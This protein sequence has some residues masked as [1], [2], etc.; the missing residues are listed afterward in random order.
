MTTGPVSHEPGSAASDAALRWGRTQEILHDVL[1]RAP[2]ERAA[3][4][5][6]ACADLT[7][8]RELEQLIAAHEHPGALDE[9]SRAVIAPLQRG[10]A[11]TDAGAPLELGRYTIIERL[12]GGGMGV[13]HRAHDPR[14]GRDVALKF[15]S[16]HL[17]ADAT[18]KKR[19]MVEARATAALE[20]PNICTIHEIGETADG[21]LYIVM[22]YYDGETLDRLIAR[23]PMAVELALR[24]AADIA[25]GLAKAHERGI[26]HRDI[27]PANVMI[28]SDGLVKILDFGIAK[29]SDSSA[30]HTTGAL[31]TTA[32]MS[33]EQASAASLDHRTDLW[34]L[35]IVLY[36]MLTGV[37]PFRGNEPAILHG[38]LH[39]DPEPVTRRRPDAPPAIESA[40][41][42]AL[43]KRA[44][45]RYASAHELI[46][47]LERIAAA[48]SSTAPQRIPA[49]SRIAAEALD[50]TPLTR[51]GER[52]QVTVVECITHDYA[53]L[54]ERLV[55]EELERLA[56]ALRE[57]A[58]EVASRYGGI[59]NHVTG[60]RLVMLFGVPVAHEDDLLR[61]ARATLE[62][63]ARARELDERHAAPA[64]GTV[65]LRS[66]VHSGVAIAQRLRSGDQR[67]HIAG[68]PAELAHRLAVHAEPDAILA[69]PEC[70][71]L[72][73]AA[74]HGEPAPP[75][76]LGDDAPP[77]TPYRLLREA[78]TDRRVEFAQRAA[79]TPYS[80]RA[81]EIALC[82]EQLAS[83]LAGAGRMVIVIGDAGT[84]KSRLL[85]EL[86]RYAQEAGVGV[87]QGRCDAF[88]RTT[89]YLPFGQALR[90]ALDVGARDDLRDRH[91]DIV[92]R[93]RGI[94]ESLEDFLPLYLSLLAIPSAT[95]P[96]PRHLQGEH[97]QAA[98]V[99]ALAALFTIRATRTPSLLA[100]EDWHWA[101]EASRELL[102]QL[103]HLVPAYPLLL[104]VTARADET[105]SWGSDDHQHLVR[106]GPLDPGA[107]RDIVRAVLGA[108]HVPEMLAR[109]LHERTGGNP[110]FLEE[111]CRALREEEIVV[112]RG[113]EAMV[114]DAPRVAHLPETVQAVI[115]TRIDR[116][117]PHARDVLRVASVFGRDFSRGLLERVADAPLDVARARASQG[118]RT[119]RPDERGA[120]VHLPLQAR[121]HAGGG[122]RQPARASAQVAARCHGARDRE[123][124]RG[125]PR[126]ALRLARSPLQPR[127]GVAARD[128][129]R[130]GGRRPRHRALP[131]RGCVEHPRPRPGLAA[132]PAGD[133]RA[134]GAARR[135]P[136]AAG[137][138]VRDARPARATASP[139]R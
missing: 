120:R 79:L 104:V 38:L 34:S 91:D 90:G 136:A 100:L 127:R 61:A 5:E 4:L 62:L 2:A 73:G 24:I 17:S 18:A 35:G 37:R 71:R 30:I 85:F 63:H 41:A 58:V 32:Y 6:A 69:S 52:R 44:A 130:H 48:A 138:A 29:L 117:E 115:R 83:A 42:R 68:S 57:A 132:T 66:G 23:G 125:S 92:A 12:G 70:R 13:V 15:L 93:I 31:G 40:L 137:A 131:V 59:V 88:G 122:V 96:V 112:V 47:D 45:D 33:P 133:E 67:F 124:P 98:L 55:P 134:A 103:T 94:G 76:V 1:A 114:R 105:A 60:D 28:T 9:L 8:R 84:G 14:L 108:Q 119:H 139:H 72:V 111:M 22:A 20:H 123:P 19:F 113:G 118:L 39:V 51:S 7:M 128:P 102:R 77:V 64:G 99:E 49:A 135:P 107:T 46:A 82:R 97:F 43:A 101:D 121:A 106:L 65:R 109:Q 26:I 21:Q 87:I 81:R 89:P 86:R 80:G 54:V 53:A 110:F 116:L 36:E 74:V 129:E 16:P 75:L 3:Y 27:K 50:E 78:G 56:R 11:T 126:A 95:H 10:R 25:R